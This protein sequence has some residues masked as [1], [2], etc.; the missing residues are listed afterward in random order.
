MSEC[1]TSTGKK[2]KTADFTQRQRKIRKSEREIPVTIAMSSGLLFK[3]EQEGYGPAF[4]FVKALKAVNAEL[5]HHYP[6]S[7]E[8]FKVIFIDDTTSSDFLMDQTCERNQLVSELRRN[9]THLYL[10]DEPNKVQEALN[11]GVAAAIMFT[12][13]NIITE[14]ENQLRVAFDGDAVLFSNESELVFKSGL[15]AFLDHEEQNVEIPMNGGPFR[16]FLEV[17]IKLQKKL[18]NT[19]LYKKCPIRT[20]LV[21]SRGAGC[22]GYRALNTLHRW[23]LELDEAVFLGGADKGPSLQRIKPHIFFDDQQ[24][25]VDAALEV[26]TVACLVPS[27][28]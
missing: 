9:N 24:R 11:A 18:N 7:N 8:L 5:R 13:T 2:R 15:Q 16:G 12:P 6:D 27:P 10:S 23:H 17:L 21:T 28:N 22:P 26:G 4:K 3:Q 19:G 1:R 14:S 20:Y 25:H